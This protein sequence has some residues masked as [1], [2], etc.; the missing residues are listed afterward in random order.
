MNQA[1]PTTTAIPSCA[2]QLT[3]TQTLFYEIKKKKRKLAKRISQKTQHLISASAR[4]NPCLST[5][6]ADNYI[7]CFDTFDTFDLVINVF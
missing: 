2:L 7:Y 4:E 3:F 1:T 6:I 5:S